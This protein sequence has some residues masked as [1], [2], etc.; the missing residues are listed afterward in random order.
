MGLGHVDANPAVTNCNNGR[1]QRSSTF[2]FSENLFS[3][4]SCKRQIEHA[5]LLHIILQVM[6]SLRLLDG[7]P[8]KSCE[9]NG[10]SP[11]KCED[12]IAVNGLCWQRKPVCRVCDPKVDKIGVSYISLAYIAA[13]C[14]C[15]HREHR[16]A[17]NV[18]ACM[19]DMRDGDA[20]NILYP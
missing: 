8:T 1:K 4:W 19:H 12:L 6:C 16:E 14:F 7:H 13:C 20:A 10:L 9:S 5:S 17:A 15:K 2:Q 18:F 3:A 11:S